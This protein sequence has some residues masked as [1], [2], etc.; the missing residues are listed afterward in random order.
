MAAGT[1]TPYGPFKEALGA[2]EVLLDGSHVIKMILLDSTHVP[3]ATNHDA[4]ADISGDEMSGNGYARFTLAPTWTRS[5]T[6]TKFAATANAVFQAL[7]GDLVGIK[8][9]VIIDDTHADK[10]PICYLDL[11]VGGGAIDDVV[12]DTALRINVPTNGFLQG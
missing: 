7:G 5:G 9:A 6:V 3:D 10:M 11:D 4:L 1:W 8:Y 2:G 12:D